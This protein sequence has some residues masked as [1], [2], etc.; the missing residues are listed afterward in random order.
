MWITVNDLG[1][2]CL[3]DYC[4]YGNLLKATT[5]NTQT[6]LELLLF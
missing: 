2:S 5:Q 1:H 6:T 3:G 4:W